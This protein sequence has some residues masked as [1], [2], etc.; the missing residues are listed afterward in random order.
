MPRRPGRARVADEVA[1]YWRYVD[2]LAAETDER[3]TYAQ[4]V[5]AISARAT[6][7]DYALTAAGGF[8]GELN[9]GWRSKGVATF[10]CEYGFSCMGYEISGGWGAAMARARLAPDG[11][12]IVFVGDG[13]YLMMN[14]DLYSSVLAGPPMIVI[15]CDNGGYAVIDRLQVNQGGESFNNLLADTRTVRRGGSRRLRRSRRVDGLYGAAGLDDRPVDEGL[16]RSACRRPHHRDR[17]RRRSARVDRRRSV[18]GGRRPRGQ[19]QAIDPRRPRGAGAGQ[20][21]PAA[22]SVSDVR[23]VVLGCGRIGR[24]HAE[25]LARRVE[26]VELAGVHDVVPPLAHSVGAQLGVPVFRTAA[27]TLAAGIDAVAI[28]TTTDTHVEL[29]E[30]AAAAGVA[31]FCEKPIALDLA[32]VDAALEAVGAAQVPLH[33]GFNRRFDPAHRAVRDA[34]A[35]GEVGTLRTLRITSRDPEPPPLMYMQRSG[36]LFL[37]M[38]IHDFDLARFISRSEVVEVF[39]SG[40]VMVDPAIGEV[41]DVD[42]AVVVMRH[43]SGS[44]TVID[45]CRQC[46]YGYDQRV[47][48]FGSAGSTASEIAGA[49]DRAARRRGHPRAADPDVLPRPLR[50]QLPVAMARLRG[51]RRRWQT[52][53][54]HRR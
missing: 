46:A 15:V 23:I 49:A 19:R 4:V 30:A 14:S 10:D 38:T 33:V 25:L 20:G 8:P 18:V 16:R 9:N 5:G 28:C 29:I 52:G 11:R 35:S 13:S 45:N 12:V 7:D 6:A 3:P 48:A 51:C 40:S 17:D 31:I 44:T 42:T 22:G 1:G 41:G 27:D 37:D 36:G 53:A 54:C 26:G 47:E 24:M 21:R 32:E 2:G 43:Q 39:A 34:V 50:R